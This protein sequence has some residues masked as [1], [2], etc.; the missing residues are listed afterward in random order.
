[1]YQLIIRTLGVKPAC[2]LPFCVTVE[3]AMVCV[4]SLLTIA[5]TGPGDLFLRGYSVIPTPQRVQLRDAEIELD[6]SWTYR[7]E[8]KPD[9]IAVRTLLSDLKVFHSLDLGVAGRKSRN[10]LVV[11]IVPGTV[12]TG[13]D[14]ETD[15][16]AYRIEI[17]PGRIDVIG[18]S[19]PGL[20]YGVQT[21]IQLIKTDAQ[22]RLRLPAC[23]VE[24]WPALRLRFIHW[25]TKHHQDRI[26]T[27]KR[28]LDWSARFKVNMIGFELED[29][30]EYPSHPVI[31]APGAFTAS[32][33]QEIVNYGLERFIQVVPQ[34]QSPAH[35]AY[36]LKHPEFE[37]LRAD[38]NNY[39]ACLCDER[40]Y[41]LI[42]SMYDD[43]IQATQGVQYFHVSTDEVYYAGICASCDRPYNPENRSLR[44][45]EFARRAHRFLQGRGRTMLAWVEYPLLTRHI[46]LLPPDVINGV[47]SDD[48][49]QVN[50]EKEHGMRQLI[51]TSMQGEESLF[52]DHLAFEGDQEYS[53]G[54]LESAYVTILA[55]AN[56]GN[57]VGVYG[58]AWDDSGLHNETFWLGWATVARY[59]WRP[60]IPSVEQNIAEFMNVF[61]GPRVT[62]MAELYRRIQAQ[63]RFYD[64]SWDRIVS[65]VR[66]PGYGNSEGRGIGTT[67]FDRTLPPPALPSLPGLDFVPVYTGRYAR[68]VDEARRMALEND[69]LL[70]LLHES[71]PKADRNR[72]SLEVFLSIA[73]LAG[74]HNRMI[75][76]MAEI[77]SRL[78]S[79]RTAAERS[80]PEDA[81]EQLQGAYRTAREVVEERKRT[82]EFLKNVWEKS[83]FPKG[84]EVNGRKFLHVLDDTKDHRADR[85]AD[86]SYLIAP[87]ESIELEQWMEKL[88]AEAQAYGR[89]SSVAVPDFR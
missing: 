25:D 3:A 50:T 46:P 8:V 81:V 14:P 15:K 30:F 49:E 74:H 16:Q 62:G 55:K 29:K 85:R 77:E 48:L 80:R 65:R 59:G 28:F 5:P 43:V 9:H 4:F 6:R 58:A 23:T 7:A 72:Y 68:L 47:M 71:I 56:L 83:R 79:A 88:A 84:Q 70:Y 63:A 53:R 87:E 33:L 11:S 38:G 20:F 36:V 32:Q 37:E 42:F 54:R 64:R 60:D 67:R 51:Y 66:G 89:S 86:L 27:L 78:R 24:D 39:Q 26:E 44:W 69:V 34:L 76:G 82:F 41:Q 52:P 31:G 13:L 35:F 75:L 57:P 12:K 2:R 21:L 40:T 22:G 19:D 61:Y 10:V 18:N 45:V 1:M 73:K 17:G